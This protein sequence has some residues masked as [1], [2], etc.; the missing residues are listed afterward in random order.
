MS[1]QTRFLDQEINQVGHGQLG[2][3]I[4][5]SAQQV[6]E[7]GHCGVGSGS[8][9]S[10]TGE[11]GALGLRNGG[12]GLEHGQAFTER[13][14]SQVL[15]GFVPN[16]PRWGVDRPRQVYVI[17]GIVKYTEIG[18]QVPDFSAAVELDATNYS[19][20]DAQPE[21]SF[22]H[23]PRLGV[24]AVHYGT[25]AWLNPISAGKFQY[26]LAHKV[27]LFLLGVSL[28]DYHVSSGRVFGS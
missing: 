2:L 10:R 7:S 28:V 24:D 19:V 21:A 13:P 4:A 17:L 1:F 14:A 18:H 8:Q 15:D 6:S 3:Q 9:G 22:F 25:T 11:A 23:G 5:E 12:N 16:A 20:L 26:L 27:C